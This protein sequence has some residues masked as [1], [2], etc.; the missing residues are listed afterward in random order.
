ME[1]KRCI[2][3]RDSLTFIW[4]KGWIHSDGKIYKTCLE[5]PGFYKKYGRRIFEGYC[6]VCKIQYHREEIDDHC[7]LPVRG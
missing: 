5:Y 1:I 7:A 6:D 3:S 2:W 4:G